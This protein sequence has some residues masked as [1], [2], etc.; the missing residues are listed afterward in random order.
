MAER[1]GE[2]VRPI[3]VNHTKVWVV[4]YH[5]DSDP[6]EL[7]IAFGNGAQFQFPAFPSEKDA[8]EWKL[9]HCPERGR[10]VRATIVPAGKGLVK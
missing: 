4:F 5:C 1:K 8:R 10:I 3:C 7:L 9:E 6:M 2:T